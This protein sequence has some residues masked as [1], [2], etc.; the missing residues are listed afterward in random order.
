MP[1]SELMQELMT[2]YNKAIEY[3]SAVDTSKT[4]SHE[5]YLLKL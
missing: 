3:Y 2:L 4:D 1:D 5:V